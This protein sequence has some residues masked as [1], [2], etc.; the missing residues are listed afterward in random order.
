MSELRELYQE[1]ILDH[2]KRPRNFGKPEAVTSEAH[3]RNPLCGDTLTVFLD[4]RDGTI[5]DIAWEG[6]GCAI[7]TASASMMTESLKGKSIEDGRSLYEWFHRLLTAPPDLGPP[8]GPLGKLAVFTGVREFPV[9]VKCATLP[10]HTLKAA[11]DRD[12]APV[13]TE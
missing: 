6:H 8:A 7:S 9:R 10:W 11:L 2:S 5:R 12:P 4:L 1:V 13:T 3:G